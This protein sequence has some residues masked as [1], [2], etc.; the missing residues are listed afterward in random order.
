MGIISEVASEVVN[1]R[2]LVRLLVRMI[3]NTWDARRLL[4]R[5]RIC[6]LFRA[7]LNILLIIMMLH[8]GGG[9]L[10]SWN[11]GILESWNPGILEYLY[12]IHYLTEEQYLQTECQY[13]TNRVRC[14]HHKEAYK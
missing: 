13:P 4:R 10:E 7:N 2:L 6:R 3:G 1:G 9:I 12:Y 5:L 11:P 14:E 8:L